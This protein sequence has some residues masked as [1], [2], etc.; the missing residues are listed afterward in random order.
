MKPLSDQ[1]VSATFKATTCILIKGDF[2]TCTC[3]CTCIY[4]LNGY[5]TSIKTVPGKSP[6]A[7]YHK[8][9]FHY[10][11]GHLPCAKLYKKLVGGVNVQSQP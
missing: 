3:I 8:S 11:G 9:Q 7:L 2:F 5:Y 6:W 4:F 10:A 1:V